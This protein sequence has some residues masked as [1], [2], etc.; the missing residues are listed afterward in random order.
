MTS[1]MGSVARAPQHLKN[2]QQWK[3]VHN[4]KIFLATEMVRNYN[5]NVIIIILK[6]HFSYTSYIFW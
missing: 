2:L 6:N 1:D 5:K 4:A 3:V